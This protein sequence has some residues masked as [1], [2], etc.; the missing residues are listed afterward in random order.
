LKQIIRSTKIFDGEH[1]PFKGHL[2][3]NSGVIERISTSWEYEDILNQGAQLLCYD[4][5]F[6]MPG[7]HDNHVF[8]SGYLGMNAGLNLNGTKSSLE[9]IERIKNEIAMKSSS[10]PI[11][12]Y[13]WDLE[14][15]K[16]EPLEE[17]LN[18]LNYSEPIVAI[19]KDRSYCWMN[20]K[21]K[22]RYGFTEKE[23]SA[24]SR[25]S[26]I[27]EMLSNPELLNSTYT[28]FEDLLLSRGVVSIKEIVFDNADFVN[29]LPNRRIFSNLYVQGVERDLDKE[30]LLSYRTKSFP[31]NVRFGGVKIMV[32]GVVA[33]ETGDIYG[34]Y[35]SGKSSPEIDYGV[36]EILVECFNEAGIPCCLTTEGN[37]AGEQVSLI[38]TENRKRLPEGVYNSISDLEM[39]TEKTAQNMRVGQVVAEIYPQILG[40]NE[41]YEEAYM[42]SITAS[43]DCEDFFNYNRLVESGVTI[44]S[45]TDLPLFITNLPES[46][47]RATYRRF[48]KGNKVWQ[49]D[50][51]LSTL[52]LLKSFTSNSFKVNHLPKYGELKAGNSATL[53]IFDTDL[54]TN[55][56]SKLQEATVIATYIDGELVYKNNKFG[57][58]VI[59][60]IKG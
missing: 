42:P 17:D 16:T 41:S 23:T 34:K 14:A 57:Y 53:A 52:N 13:G 28:K 7:I 43:D 5:Q 58:N 59:K 37:C 25:V 51:S 8:F 47:I 27:K 30:L 44:T 18:D 22:N 36:I 21:A 54:F 38:L 26:L 56:F 29:L 48:P 50:G 11:Y 39:I 6:V 24:E 3:I 33:D 19:D 49:E 31:K 2:V 20:D 46:I 4:E 45:G 9:A 40:L 35:A 55:D 1:L 10:E 60:R 12:A 15:W 32:D